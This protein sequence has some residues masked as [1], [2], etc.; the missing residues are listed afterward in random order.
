MNKDDTPHPLDAPST[1]LLIKWAEM[2]VRSRVEKALR[3]LRLSSGQLLLL[4]LLERSGEKTPA[5]LSRA[6]H[7]TPQAMTT[8]LKPLEERKL[9]ARREDEANRRRI[10]L[11]LTDEARAI[12]REV[13]ALTPAIEAD[14]IAGTLD[15]G[16]VSALRGLLTR[17]AAPDI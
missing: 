3:P 2:A 1:I 9:L 7:V 10:L 5:A 15:S 8:L 13:R 16:E 14:L 12:L 11:S 6:L 4:V 17:I